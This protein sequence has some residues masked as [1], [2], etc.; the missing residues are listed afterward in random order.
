MESLHHFT[1]EEKI[2]LY[3]KL[4][5]AL[6]PGRYFILTDY[7]ALTDEEERMHRAELLRLKAEQGVED[8]G[9]YHYDTPL[10]VAHECE[11]LQKAGFASVEILGRWGA[12]HTI[13]A[14]KD[15]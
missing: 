3:T 5:Q 11:A 15:E 9:F 6:K 13:K 12:T 4:H 10:T 1:Q 7:F 8:S 2:P 14:V